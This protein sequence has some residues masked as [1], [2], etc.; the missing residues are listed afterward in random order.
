M[1]LSPSL[2]QTYF[3]RKATAKSEFGLER[4]QTRREPYNGL[5]GLPQP[6]KWCECEVDPALTKIRHIHGPLTIAAK[7]AA[8]ILFGNALRRTL[9]EHPALMRSMI[10]VSPAMAPALLTPMSSRS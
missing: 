4:F 8:A 6:G 3:S 2:V 10:A 5:P 9:R 1:V 7:Q